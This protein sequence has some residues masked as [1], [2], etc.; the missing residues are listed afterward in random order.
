MKT[1]KVNFIKLDGVKY[2]KATL[3][4]VNG[5]GDTRQSAIAELNKKL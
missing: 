3:N 1:I 2:F 4:S 5:Y